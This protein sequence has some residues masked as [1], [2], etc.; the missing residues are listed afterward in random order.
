MRRV[1]LFLF[2]LLSASL[3]VGC[4]SLPGLR[5]LTGQNDAQTN[6]DQTV[7][8]L[9]LVMA[10]KFGRTDP[11]VT[12]AADRI[13]AAAGNVDIIEIRKNDEERT[14]QVN[15]LFAPP[16]VDT[17]TTNGQI[18]LL[19]SLR[20]AA[21]LTWQGMMQAS[22]GTD[23]LRILILGAQQISTLDNGASYI[24]IVQAQMEIDRADAA[25][26]LAGT[27]SLTQFNDLIVMGTLNYMT[28][29][30]LTLY[31]GQPN[32]PM[33]MLPAAPQ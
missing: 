16:R 26:Y 27:R 3:I 24:G 5:V 9:D 6:A 23:I 12:A 13:E 32:H 18:A 15:L 4:S 8:A 20:R 7:Q 31:E 17:S 11:A 33:F 1:Y 30:E 14:F 2:V 25:A 21:E 10:D 28:P 22:E 19:D 29:S